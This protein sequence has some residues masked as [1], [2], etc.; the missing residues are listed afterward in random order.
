MLNFKLKVCKNAKV[1]FILSIAVILIGL[2]AF[3][4]KGLNFGIDFV[5][6]T[7]AQIELGTSYESSDIR[8]IT[9]S[10]DPSCEITSAGDNNTQ[11]VISSRID[12]TDEQKVT[13]FN[14]FKEK[15]NLDDSALL[16]FDNV[17]ASFGKVLQQQALSAS[18]VTVLAILIYVW[19]RFEFLFGV[20]AIMSLLHDLLIVVGFY[21]IFQIPVNSSFIAAILTILG[22]SINDTIV[23]FDRIRENRRKYSKFDYVNLIDDSINQSMGRTINTTLTTLLAVTALYFFGVKAI[24]EILLPMVIGFVSGVYSTI[25]VASTFWYV[26]KESQAKKIQAK[27]KT[28]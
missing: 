23:I 15:Y 9:D 19:I 11:V 17:S 22:Y 1:F 16:S 4:I 27:R 21:A 7:I 12:F 3:F 28:R 25:F 10:Y 20:A 14:A 5:G 24:Q 13:F 18:L 6:G 2:G 26:T 8:A